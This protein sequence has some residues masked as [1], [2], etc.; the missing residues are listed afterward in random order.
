MNELFGPKKI[1]DY[2]N[3][4]RTRLEKQI[5]I[6]DEHRLTS[7]VAEEEVDAIL[8]RNKISTPKLDTSKTESFITTENIS[9]FKLPVG[10]FFERGKLYEIE[11]ANYKISF[12][13]TLDLFNYSPTLNTGIVN[14]VI[15]NVNGF[16]I[17]KFTPYGKI[18][19][20]NEATEMIKKELLSKIEQ[21]NTNLYNIE[22]DLIN[23][24]SSIRT[25]LIN[26]LTDRIKYHKQ[27]MESSDKLNPFL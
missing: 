10:T 19:G 3:Q 18:T 26:Q 4:T 6:F 22:N 14:E 16:L 23:F 20:N 13:G 24:N 2:F 17:F 5:N 15:L 11:I 9:G 7:I 21:I 12:D 8:N 1:E 25:I 27:K